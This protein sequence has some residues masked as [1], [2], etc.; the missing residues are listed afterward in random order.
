MAGNR[1]LFRKQGKGM[2]V[3][4]LA[5][6]LFT[7][8]TVLA[9]PPVSPPLAH[10]AFPA[11]IPVCPDPIPEGQSDFAGM[12][13]PG[14]FMIT[15]VYFYT[16]ITDHTAD[17][18]DFTGY[19]GAHGSY[20]S[21]D[22]HDDDVLRI[23]VVTTQDTRPEHDETFEIGVISSSGLVSCVITIVDDDA[24]AVTD[25]D[26]T[27]NPIRGD[28]YRGGENIDVT[29]TFDKAVE[30]V[31]DASVTLHLGEGVDPTPREAEYQR[32]SG[33]RFL[34]FRYEVQPSDRDSD[35]ITV[36]SAG[37][38][39]DH[40]PVHG[41]SG[42]L[43]ARGTDVPINY[44]HAGVEVASNHKVDGRPY[45]TN[46]GAIS[47]PPEGWEAYQ[48][49]Q[50]IEIALD[51]DTEVVVEGEVRLALYVGLVRDNWTEAWREA[52]YLR[53]S[54]TD[55]L[56]FGYTV[57][58]GDMDIR[59]IVIPHGATAVLGS[60][61]IKA[62]GTDVEYLEHFPTTGHL[63]D[64]KIDTA[65]PTI[66]GIDFTSWPAD[67]EAYRIG[68]VISVEVV[69]TEP[70]AKDG[71]LQLELDIGGTTRCA[72]LQPDANPD[73]RFDN[74]LVFEYQVQAGD[75]D[76]DGIGIGANSLELN[77][78]SL[79]D[80]AGNPAILSHDPVAANPRQLVDT[81]RE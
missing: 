3:V 25:V 28:T 45:V 76:S 21:H 42:I 22:P 64:Q 56:V 57:E 73:R 61:T 7:A 51:F 4:S 71:D 19:S 6:T 41:F 32:G 26:I 36:S 47:S 62:R 37:E 30:V 5:A 35:G 72:A 23:P 70:V 67:R 20:S 75:A 24:P 65:S 16:F 68:D 8:L 43:Y 44:T 34:V 52:D 50:T 39:E 27:S 33:T 13:W 29:L 10:A 81:S 38:G 63:P 17:F 79:H 60:G 66:S 15:P 14:S 9:V 2:T 18:S 53:G 49:G 58:P 48:A 80:R 12:R 78:G 11:P 31:G 40:G 54:G 69:F 1:I 77:G 59:G 46:V 55:T 74:D